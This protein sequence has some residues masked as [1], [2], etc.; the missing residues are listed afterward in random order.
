MR[1]GLYEISNSI[2]MMGLR[3][4]EVPN[5]SP[6]WSQCEVFLNRLTAS[7]LPRPQEMPSACL[8]SCSMPAV[9]MGQTLVVRAFPAD[10]GDPWAPGPT[11]PKY[12]QQPDILHLPLRDAL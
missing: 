11:K 4:V 7:Y 1:K 9:V 12:S 8:W 5:A 2:M 10:P 6:S 3:T